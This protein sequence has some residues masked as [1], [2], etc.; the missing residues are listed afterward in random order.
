MIIFI[1]KSYLNNSRYTDEETMEWHF[2]LIK[3]IYMSENEGSKSS[4]EAGKKP[5]DPQQETKHLQPTGS[6]C[7]TFTQTF[8]EMIFQGTGLELFSFCL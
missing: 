2:I 3:G 7:F 5:N 4:Y 1:F 6:L 8:L